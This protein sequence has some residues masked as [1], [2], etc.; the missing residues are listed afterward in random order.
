M[1]L[2]APDSD[3]NLIRHARTHGLR[4]WLPGLA[5]LSQYTRAF[6]FQDLA[7]GVVLTA[8]LAPVGIGYAEAIG[9]PPIY[10]LYATIVPLL[11]YALFGPSR[12]LILGPDSAVIV[13]VGAT[14]LPLSGGDGVRA[15]E[16]A[17]LL[18]IISGVMCI[19]AGLARFG[20]VTDLLS[21]PI[22]HGYMNGIALTLL[23]GQF[24]KL[25]GFSVQGGSF[26]E[27]SADLVR[28]IW[29]GRINGV[30]CSLGLSC[31]TIILGVRWWA[32]RLPGLL[33]AVVFSA[34][35]VG[36]FDLQSLA[37]VA[38][39]GALP[40]GLPAF[41]IPLVTLS[42][43][44]TLCTGALAIALVSIADMSVLSRIY[45]LRGGYYVDDNQEL[46]ALGIA[47]VATGLFQGFSVS[48]SASRTPVAESAGARTQ[49]TGVV[50]ALCVGLLLVFAPRLMQYLPTA[51]LGAVVIS[52]CGSIFEIS[53]VRRLYDL[54]RGEF[55]LSMVC[56]LGVV[57]LGVIQGIFIAVGMAL[58]VFIWRAWRPYCAVLGRVDGMKGYHDITRHPE[59]RRIPGLVLFRWDA[60]LF[61]ANA[62][63]F[64]EQTL[65]AV[66]SAPTPTKWLV[67]AA[68]PVTD[69]DITAADVLAELE[70]EL[71]QAGIELCFAQMKGPVKDHLKRYGL[72][73]KLGTENFFPTI[74]QAVDH[75]VEKYHVDW[76]DWEDVQLPNV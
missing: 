65:R 23:I 62:E 2:T 16:L 29:E 31:L 56:C 60:P 72:F 63:I 48:S 50:G 53:Q 7:A 24:P 33:I 55:Y 54:R 42:E 69:V 70:D 59:A 18:A 3:S 10:G 1:P 25:F 15:A 9:L 75:Y 13:L 61:F 44:T 46:I 38:V 47:N 27:S 19:L 32:P 57:A 11:A 45:A 76:I 66:S 4:R 58:L 8:L 21:K 73:V 22:R 35:L 5:L 40:Q 20:F 41:Q 43:L 74:G 49:M 71:N 68:E 34:L 14:I 67:V 12:I 6:F 30:S 39:V 26:L 37:Q 17:A 36:L 52:A 28:G 64:R 51:A